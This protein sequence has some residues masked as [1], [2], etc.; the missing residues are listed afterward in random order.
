M[1]VSSTTVLIFVLTILSLEIYPK[2]EPE[3]INLG[4]CTM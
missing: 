3:E 2:C 1:Q 4:T